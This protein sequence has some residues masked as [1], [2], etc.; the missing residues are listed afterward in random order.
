MAEPLS[1]S[2]HRWFQDRI[3]TW[4]MW[5]WETDRRLY[6]NRRRWRGALQGQIRGFSF[7]HLFA[8]IPGMRKLRPEQEKASNLQR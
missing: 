6:S 1:S 7:R 8:Y 3:V 2:H 4:I 5:R